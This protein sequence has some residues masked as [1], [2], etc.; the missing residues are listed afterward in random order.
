MQ[1]WEFAFVSANGRKP[2]FMERRE[3][4]TQVRRAT[5]L[6]ELR[7]R[8]WPVLIGATA[9]RQSAEG[10]AGG[11]S[12]LYHSLVARYEAGGAH[13]TISMSTRLR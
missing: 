11:S 4:A 2:S 6:I 13:G 9:R 12:M 1:Q 10:T 8:V 3:D 7:Q 5:E